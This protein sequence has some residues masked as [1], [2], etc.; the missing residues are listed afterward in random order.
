MGDDVRTYTALSDY[1]LDVGVGM[2]SIV[3]VK[4]TRAFV[5]AFVAK[6]VINGVGGVRFLLSLRS[7]R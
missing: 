4:D 5:S 1:K 2:E 6:T 7:Y 3:T